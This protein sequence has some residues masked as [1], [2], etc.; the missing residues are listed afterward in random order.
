MK[1]TSRPI[2][3]LIYTVL[4]LNGLLLSIFASW[5]YLSINDARNENTSNLH[6]AKTSATFSQDFSLSYYPLSI[7]IYQLDSE[8]NIY[9]RELEEISINTNKNIEKVEASLVNLEAYEERLESIWPPQM[10]STLKENISIN[11]LTILE[12][13]EDIETDSTLLER[14]TLAEDSSEFIAEVLTSIEAVKQQ[15]NSIMLRATMESAHSTEETESNVIALDV[16]LQTMGKTL[17]VIFAVIFLLMVATQIILSKVITIR[18]TALKNYAKSIENGEYH[19]EIPF[20]SNDASGDLA[21]SVKSMSKTLISLLANSKKLTHQAEEASKAKSD[22]LANMSHEI[23]TPMNAILGFSEILTRTTVS[24]EDHQKFAK[25]IYNASK[26]L[27]NILNDLLDFSKMEAGK[28]EILTAPF[29]LIELLDRQLHLFGATVCQKNIELNYNI[30]PSVPRL[31]KADSQRIGQVL[32]N[33]VGNAV[34]FT[35]WGEIE[36]RVQALST[37]GTHMMLQFS[38]RDTGVGIPKQHQDKLFHSFTQVDASVTRN[39]GGTGLG[40]AICHKLVELMGGKITLSSEEDQGSTFTFTIN[41]E[42]SARNLE[43]PAQRGTLYFLVGSTMLRNGLATSVQREG[44]SP[45]CTNSLA[46]LLDIPNKETGEL[47]IIDESTIS[48]NPPKAIDK[49]K[50]AFGTATPIIL[51]T[52]QE[53]SNFF[54]EGNRS[55]LPVASI[56]EKPILQAE[57]NKLITSALDGTSIMSSSQTKSNDSSQSSTKDSLRGLQVLVAEDQEPNQLLVKM[58]LDDLGVESTICGNGER[59]VR[60]LQD[61]RFDL[62]LMD[63]QMPVMGGIEATKIIRETHTDKE[64]P[65]IAL[66]AKAMDIDRAECKNAG[67]NDF[68]SKPYVAEELINVLNRWATSTNSE[69]A[70]INIEEGL[71]RWKGNAE[72]YF[73]QIKSLHQ[74]SDIALKIGLSVSHRDFSEALATIHAFRGVIANLS[75]PAINDIA[76]KLENHISR[77]EK[78]PKTFDKATATNIDKLTTELSLGFTKVEN[79]TQNLTVDALKNSSKNKT[80]D[81]TS[82]PG[83]M[84]KIADMIK[85]ENPESK[86]L[87][88]P[89]RTSLPHQ[90]DL[91]SLMMTLKEQVENQEYDDASNTL[92]LLSEHLGIELL[93]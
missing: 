74:H 32:T 31:I 80:P 54:I 29:D 20:T 89:L 34:K 12:L 62:V 49:I 63:L 11:I 70:T 23:R 45:E 19:K 5:F 47:I 76:I 91:S 25:R 37:T 9:K 16:T 81:P 18:L 35:P 53:V 27:L 14:K 72:V 48:F 36:I 21:L 44:F 46:Q 39:Y 58:I 93:I 8:I 66:S 7:Y 55:S 90:A 30:D 17:L 50:A 24:I 73:E 10:Q 79:F 6:F 82:C 52:S 88:G 15:L 33:L 67:M 22:F 86:K 87:L 3:S 57:L 2:S 85:N 40:L 84:I 64:L 13:G 42:V 26:G 65:I 68:A 60:A 41:A 38:I 71:K 4:V 43:S 59:A 56:L 83:I 51:L 1:P 92:H 28:L 75:L 78:R 69:L 77:I 61:N